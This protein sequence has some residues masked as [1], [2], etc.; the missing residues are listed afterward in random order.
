MKNDLTKYETGLKK[1]NQLVN[2]YTIQTSTYKM[3]IDGCKSKLKSLDSVNF[4]EKCGKCYQDIPTDESYI[5][6]QKKEVSKQ[7]DK[8]IDEH[9]TN[10]ELIAQYRAKANKIEVKIKEFRETLNENAANKNKLSSLK[11]TL[12]SYE[13]SLEELDVDLEDNTAGLKDFDKS[14][15]ETEER[16]TTEQ[17]TLKELRQIGEDYDMCKFILGEE[18]VKSFMIKRL[19]SMLNGSIQKYITELGMTMRCKFDEYFDEQIAND[20]NKPISYWNLSGGERRTVDLACAWAF[21]D[22]KTKISGVSS[23]VEF[24][25]E[26][27][28]SAFDERGLDLFID[29]LKERITKNK[30]SCYTISHRK[31]TLK[32]IDGETVHVE[33]ENGITRRIVS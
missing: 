7:M 25:D 9:S 14:I 26:V 28:D 16:L 18:G 8:N 17:E 32:H 33:K 29:V 22:I 4:G 20:K 2:D 11:T 1:V 30:L 27:F 13:R 24:L 6:D 31:E 10:T 3:N 12:E 21:K 5:T 15:T 23:N 19:L